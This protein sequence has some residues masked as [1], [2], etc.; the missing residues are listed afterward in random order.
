M[1]KPYFLF[2]TGSF[3]P[4]VFYDDMVNRIKAHGY[5]IKALQLPTVGLGPGLGRDTPPATMYDDAAFIAKEAEALADAGREIILVAHSY[6]GMPA[7]ES[8]KGLSAQ[9]RQREGK[10]GGIIRL[11]YKTVLLTNPGHSASEVL[12]PPQDPSSGPQLDDKGWLT[13]VDAEHN[14]AACFSDLAREQGLYYHSQFA[15][16]SAVSFINKLTYAGYKD[17]PVSY[18]FC[19]D[20]LVVPAEVQRREIEMIETET[21]SKVDVTSIKSGHCPNVSAPE[22]VVDWFL[23]VASL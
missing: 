1:S 22:K 21:G 3:V 13:L 8:I 14:A 19:E 2:V 17:V 23:H 15:Q 11:A 16:H 4:A 5:D 18:L 12:P 10:K 7:T 9:D 6:G 20:D